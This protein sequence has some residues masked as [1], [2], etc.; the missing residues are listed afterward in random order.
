MGMISL[1]GC[2]F[3]PPLLWVVW[4]TLRAK[5]IA[6][7]AHS[8]RNGYTALA[9]VFNGY[10]SHG[11]FREQISRHIFFLD[12]L[13]TS[14]CGLQIFQTA[15]IL[16][17]GATECCIHSVL[18]WISRMVLSTSIWGGD[19][20]TISP[21]DY[22]T[23]Q[24]SLYKTESFPHIL[25]WGGWG[26][27]GEGAAYCS[28]STFIECILFYW[29][30]FQYEFSQQP[31][32]IKTCSEKTHPHSFFFVLLGKSTELQKDWKILHFCLRRDK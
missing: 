14:K 6:K 3:F 28:L 22:I 21:G 32:K 26:G 27:G 1:V 8:F 24:S 19:L 25:G 7:V 31:E 15:A 17:H 18:T 2:L 11:K 10:E 4:E 29:C 16:Q 12:T 23:C 9:W 13:F 5:K 30:I 20:K